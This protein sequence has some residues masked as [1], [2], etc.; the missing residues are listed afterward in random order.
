MRR[1]AVLLS[2]AACSGAEAPPAQI[3]VASAP[4]SASASGAAEMRPPVVTNDPVLP[5]AQVFVDAPAARFPRRARLAKYMSIKATRA[6][7]SFGSPS[8][9]TETGAGE[10]VVV[11]NGPDSVRVLL[12]DHDAALR[13][14]AYVP[15][16]SLHEVLVEE[17]KLA[18]KGGALPKDAAIVGL[19][20][21][22]V[23][24]GPTRGGRRS[25]HHADDV[26]ALEAWAPMGATG[27]VYERGP[28][29]AKRGTPGLAA[30]KE[31]L[32]DGPGGSEIGRLLGE[33]TDEHDVRILGAASGGY[34][35]IAV[36]RE[37]LRVEAWIR[38]GKVT[39]VTD[40][41]ELFGMGGLGLYGSSH[42][43]PVK[44]PAGTA[45]AAT[46]GGEQ[47]GVFLKELV[48]Y[49]NRQKSGGS[50]EVT[51]PFLGWDWIEVWVPEPVLV[52]AHADAAVEERRK[53]RVRFVLERTSDGLAKP[54]W[55]GRRVPVATCVEKAEDGKKPL[56]GKF[57]VKI[58]AGSPVKVALKG[59]LTKDKKLS[60]CLEQA[61]RLEPTTG[62]KPATS[63]TLECT[64]EVDPP[65]KP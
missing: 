39:E 43:F 57:E 59:A 22:L 46:A 53:R 51:F 40:E 37:W 32:L 44:I 26:V 27:R 30:G 42:G 7:E 21:L 14:A 25:F 64:V 29:K 16:E 38:A 45:L 8:S 60:A 63:G 4:A 5:S 1:A 55:N 11:E 36:D 31:P 62:G 52:R 33:A 9:G 15:S 61:V 10:V 56:S 54:D 17:T 12:E 47:I 13:I 2:L 65:A 58:S 6:S 23:S 24:G 41:D 48:V 3:G 18:A 28:A 34:R 50:A 19:P 49:D 35:K 20:G